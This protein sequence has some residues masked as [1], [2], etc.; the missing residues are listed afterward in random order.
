[1]K[2]WPIIAETIP[3]ISMDTMKPYYFEYR[4]SPSEMGNAIIIARRRVDDISR[5]GSEYSE[6]ETYD[7]AV[8]LE[9]AIKK[10]P[11]LALDERVPELKAERRR[12]IIETHFRGI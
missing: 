11:F 7:V 1:M 3:R 10:L 5:D 9:A 8:S 2:Q 12:R 4:I 6:W